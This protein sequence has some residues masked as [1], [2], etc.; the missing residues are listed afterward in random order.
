[1]GIHCTRLVRAVPMQPHSEPRPVSVWR[2]RTTKLG[3]ETLASSRQEIDLGVVLALSSLSARRQQ[4]TITDRIVPGPPSL[5]PQLLTNHPVHH[6]AVPIRTVE[7]MS[8]DV[9]HLVLAAAFETSKT[10]LR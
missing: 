4:P 7:G 9:S 5:G 8:L 3:K 1:M 6:E 2:L 10:T